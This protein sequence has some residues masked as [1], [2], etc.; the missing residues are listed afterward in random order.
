MFQKKQMIYSSTQGV[1]QVDNIVNLSA[2]RGARSLQY[3]VLK[4]VSDPDRMSYIPV[5]N[6]QVELRDLF[7]KEEAIALKENEDAKGDKTLMGA[8]EYVLAH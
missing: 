8:V 7:S 1:C 4:P 2:G 5:E 3:Y 6:H